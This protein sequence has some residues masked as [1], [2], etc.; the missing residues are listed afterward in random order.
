MQ[1]L[2]YKICTNYPKL[3]LK[4]KT[5]INTI[6]PHSY[7]IAKNDLSFKTA[8]LNSD[9]LLPDGIGI[10][11]AAKTLHNQR[12]Q[13]IAGYD[14]FIYLMEHLNKTNGSCF[15]LGASKNTLNLIKKRTCNDYPNVKVNVYSPPYKQEFSMEDSNEMIVQV[16]R[17]NPAVLF[18][19]MTAPKQ[20]KWVYQQK[21]QL[22]PQI[23]CSIGAVFDFYAGTVKR[24]GHFWI[25]L[26]LE[27]L[28]RFLKEPRRLAQR[29][30]KSTPKFILAVL[31]SK[32]SRKNDF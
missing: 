4:G 1:L 12:I 31:Q 22:E 32:I 14:I 26:G 21:D 5:I 27:W 16:N 2:G 11:W 15:F 25:R 17:H 9:V 10:V 29:N 30:L 8:L 13:K 23:I 28:P 7:C 18:V 20:E 6:N 19:G 3:P 24:P